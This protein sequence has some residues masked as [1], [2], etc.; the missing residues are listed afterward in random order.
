MRICYGNIEDVL[1]GERH[2]QICV[3]NNMVG[4]GAYEHIWIAKRHWR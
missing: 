4:V 1:R 3:N 2:E